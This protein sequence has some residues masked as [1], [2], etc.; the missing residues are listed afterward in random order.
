M[1]LKP[2]MTF[3]VLL[4]RQQSVAIKAISVCR[5]VYATYKGSVGLC[6]C[7]RVVPTGAGIYAAHILIAV[8]FLS[9]AKLRT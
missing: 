7:V 1:A 4:V 8:G 9:L 3:L 6:Y 5:M 2:M